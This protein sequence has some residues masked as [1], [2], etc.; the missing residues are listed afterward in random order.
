M[1]SR[2]ASTVVTERG[3]TSIPAGVRKEMDLRPGVHLRW[4]R[5]SEDELRVSVEREPQGDPLAMLGFASRFR[6]VRSTADWMA[7]LRDGER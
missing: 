2:T 3:Q 4:E 1:R 5:V 6:P 7:E